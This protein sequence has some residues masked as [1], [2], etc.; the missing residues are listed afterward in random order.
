MLI[1]TG[2]PP[3][4]SSP[5]NSFPQ[6][7]SPKP[8]YHV[9]GKASKPMPF[10]IWK[11]PPNWIWVSLLRWISYTS[12]SGWAAVSWRCHRYLHLG[13]TASLWERR[14]LWRNGQ[15]LYTGLP[16]AVCS[17]CYYRLVHIV[18][19]GIYLLWSSP[20]LHIY[21]YSTQIWAQHEFARIF[22]VNLWGLTS[23]VFIQVN[24]GHVETQKTNT[25]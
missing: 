2:H 5:L 7:P 17:S 22:G 4:L 3:L 20:R 1:R 19:T 10:K 13:G 18:C 25:L 14:R 8:S 9:D 16:E 12:T 6:K 23:P 11:G 21:Q 24:E 15:V